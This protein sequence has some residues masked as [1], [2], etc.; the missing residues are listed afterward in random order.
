MRV[1]IETCIGCGECT[2]YC[3][4]NALTLEKDHVTVNKEECVEC[5]I[6]YYSGA[7][8]VDALQKEE[9]TWPRAV[10]GVFSDPLQSH[11]TT[12]VPGRGTEEMKTNDVTGRF[13]EGYAGIAVELGRPGTGARFRDVEK[14]AMTMARL[15]VKFEEKNPVTSLMID[16]TSGKLRDD[17]LDEKVLSAIVEFEVP[18]DKMQEVLKALREVSFEIDTLFS[19]DLICRIDKNNVAPAAELARAAGFEPSLNGKTNVG[20]GRPLAETR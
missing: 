3:P 12:G 5:N 16:K 9:L 1:D 18:L 8:P 15:G 11:S 2:H 19:L 17:V 4:M 20:L 14:V 7:C 10:R 6:C 13:K